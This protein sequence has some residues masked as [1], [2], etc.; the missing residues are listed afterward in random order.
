VNVPDLDGVNQYQTVWELEAQSGSPGETV[1]VL[2][3]TV[4][5]NGTVEISVACPYRSFEGAAA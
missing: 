1:A 2:V 5:W 4:V 3:S